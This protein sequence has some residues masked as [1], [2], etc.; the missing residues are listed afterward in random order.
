MYKPVVV[1]FLFMTQLTQLPQLTQ[2]QLQINFVAGTF[3][4]MK[5]VA[6]NQIPQI[7]YN[8][9]CNLNLLLELSAGYKNTE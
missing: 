7:K 3:G 9:C 8:S 6:N 4:W 2:R 1:L 5:W